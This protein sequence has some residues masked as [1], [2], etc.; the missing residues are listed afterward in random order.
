MTNEESLKKILVPVDR[1]ESSLA[2]QETAA[3]IAKNTGATVTLVHV[4]PG[5]LSSQGLERTY[6]I[7]SN[8][9]D[10]IM[11]DLHQEAERIVNNAQG[12]FSEENVKADGETLTSD[13]PADGILEFENEDYDLIVMGGRG[14]NEKE[15]YALGSVTKKVMMHT[16]SPLL[17][18]KDVCALSNVLV[19]VDGSKHS[20]KALGFAL[21]LTERL[22]SKMALI[23]VQERR[24]QKASPKV[25]EELAQKIFSSALETVGRKE[26]KVDKKL[27]FGVP[28]DVIV[29][30][31]E[32]GNF[33]LIILGSRGLGKV[34]RFLLGSVSD[35]VSHKA[36]CSV[37]IVPA[38]T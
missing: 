32:K 23:N 11:A 16:K 7:P 38:R 18:A 25:A 13:D 30:V 4:V 1:S 20:M 36:K 15:P 8:V 29:E 9:A 2:A 22:N 21:K 12:L 26:F 35:D 6:Q 24:L 19:C 14:E 34:K 5:A 27:E 10:E 28:S 31:A 3:V 17:I 37:L 33:D